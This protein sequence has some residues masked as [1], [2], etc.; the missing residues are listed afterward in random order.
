[1]RLIV[2]GSH[3]QTRK[4][5]LELLGRHG[6]DLYFIEDFPEK[7]GLRIRPGDICIY[8]PESDQNPQGLAYTQKCERNTQSIAFSTD[9][10]SSE[11]RIES[12]RITAFNSFD[13]FFGSKIVRF[14]SKKAKELFAL[15]IDRR[16]SFVQAG[17]AIDKLWPDRPF[18]E[19]AKQLYRR[20]VNSIV[21]TL[22]EYGIDDIFIKSRG[23]CCIDIGRIECDYYMFLASPVRYGSLFKGEYMKDYSW[24]E[25]TAAM[26][27]DM[28]TLSSGE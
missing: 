14:R 26:L 13:V 2:N 28:K 4:A 12:I 16:G 6:I 9:A 23:Q 22:S 5:L 27:L 21:S 8:L 11:K 24:A 10:G 1:M 17:E 3:E 7:T 15:C 18:D 25:S 20:A 19:N